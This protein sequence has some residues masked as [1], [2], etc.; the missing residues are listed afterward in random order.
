MKEEL[1]DATDTAERVKRSPLFTAAARAG[2]VVSGLLHVLIGFVAIRIAFGA[3]G[4]KADLSGAVALIAA[5]PGGLVMLWVGGVACA[6]LCLW[7]LG[8]ALFNHGPRKGG[9]GGHRKG[10]AL[11]TLSSLAQVI[12]YALLAVTFIAFA[13]G[14]AS[15]SSQSTSDWTAKL[16]KLPWGQTALIGLGGVIAIV[17]FG[18]MIRGLARAFRKQLI[19]PHSGP[20]RTCVTV[21]GVAGYVAKGIVLLLV[22]LLFIMS[23]LGARPQQSTGLDGALKGL[24]AQ[25]DGVYVLVFVGAGLICYGLYLMV[26]ARYADMRA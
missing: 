1:R 22:G 2:F 15:S 24:R 10:G 14:H 12:A 9:A 16:M 17:G 13:F 8:N 25:P 11:H 21:L 20:V 18:F 19:L 7:N 4:T 3:T 6:V 5:D 26:K 23:S